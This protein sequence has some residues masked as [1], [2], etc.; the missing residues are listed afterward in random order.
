MIL[1]TNVESSIVVVDQLSTIPAMDTKTDAGQLSG[2]GVVL[3]NSILAIGLDTTDEAAAVAKV[4]S[5]LAPLFKANGAL[6]KDNVG[7]VTYTAKAITLG[8]GDKLVV[9]LSVVYLSSRLMLALL[10]LPL[11]LL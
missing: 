8:A 2:A 9:D 3:Q 1:P 5:E 10:V 11:P 7:A 6:D 4:K